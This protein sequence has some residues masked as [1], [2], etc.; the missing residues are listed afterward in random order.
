[1]NDAGFRLAQNVSDAL[2]F[3]LPSRLFPVEFI[4]G[5]VLFEEEGVVARRSASVNSVTGFHRKPSK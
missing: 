3:K 4:E 5:I 1:V 2:A